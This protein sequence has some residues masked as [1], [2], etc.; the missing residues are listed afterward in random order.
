MP[1]GLLGASSGFST[2]PLTCQ[3]VAPPTP[4]ARAARSGWRCGVRTSEF[5]IHEFPI[6]SWEHDV[7]AEDEMLPRVP[8]A[9]SHARHFSASDEIFCMDLN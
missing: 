4:R 1:G 7:D 2:T 8:D 9:F 3:C 5:P 6:H